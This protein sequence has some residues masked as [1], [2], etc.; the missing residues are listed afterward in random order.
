MDFLCYMSFSFPLLVSSMVDSL[1]KMQN[2]GSKVARDELCG[3]KW[4]AEAV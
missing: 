2:R 4:V 1:S 3:G